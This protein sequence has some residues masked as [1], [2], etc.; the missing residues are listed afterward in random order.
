MNT[1]DSYGFAQ[2]SGNYHVISD[3]GNT[4][5]VIL[6]RNKFPGPEKNP[7]TG[8]YDG[9]EWLALFVDDNGNQLLPNVSGFTVKGDQPAF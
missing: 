1:S 6:K 7:S 4:V 2:T 5:E 3:D 8:K 9:Y